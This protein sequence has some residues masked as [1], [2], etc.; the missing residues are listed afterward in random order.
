VKKVKVLCV[1]IMVSSLNSVELV[2]IQHAMVLSHQE[3]AR[4]LISS[5][6]KDTGRE[7]TDLVNTQN[8]EL[9]LSQVFVP[10]AL[11]KTAMMEKMLK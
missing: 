4:D 2:A 11:L 3:D 9:V 10:Q 5:M 7:S 6:N 8:A 1:K